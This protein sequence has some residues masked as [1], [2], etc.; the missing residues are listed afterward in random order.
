LTASK[1]S[2][3]DVIKLIASNKPFTE[4][5]SNQKDTYTQQLQENIK[6]HKQDNS[7]VLAEVSLAISILEK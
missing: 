1:P 2:G 3:T 7:G 5:L 4:Q 6:Q